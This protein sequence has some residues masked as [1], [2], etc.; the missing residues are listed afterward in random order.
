[1]ALKEPHWSSDIFYMVIDEIH[2]VGQCPRVSKALHFPGDALLI[3]AERSPALWEFARI[4]GSACQYRR[5]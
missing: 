5:V 4:V 3:H 1:M 2:C